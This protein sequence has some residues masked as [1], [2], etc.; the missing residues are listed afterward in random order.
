MYILPDV[1][2][3]INIT[4]TA[5]RLVLA[6]IIGGLIG[7]ERG[8][9]N[10]A[11]GFRTH[12]LVCVGSALVMLTNEYICYLYGAGDPAR[13][14]AQVITGVGFLGAGTI[15][16]TGR[17]KIK[18]LT[19]AA[20]LWA[21]ACLGLAIGIGYYSGALIAAGLVLLSLALLPKVEDFFYKMTKSMDLY[22]E[23]ESVEQFKVFVKYLRSLETKHFKTEIINEGSGLPGA[24]CFQLDMKLGKGQNYEEILDDIK[25]FVG[26][27][28]VEEM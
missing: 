12:I 2:Y 14:G 21:S 22:I 20:G 1:F 9:S 19:T 13:L 6:V 8:A 24:I 26:V 11:A 23:I 5:T 3:D 15:M 4:S 18:G 7:L 25:A 28:L 16:M 10:H 27:W 17:N